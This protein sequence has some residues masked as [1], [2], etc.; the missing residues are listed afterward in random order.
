MTQAYIL[1]YRPQHINELDLT[2]IREGLSK[3]LKSNKVPHALLLTGPRGSGKTSAAR[4]ISKALNCQSKKKNSFEPCNRCSICQE[5][6]SGTSLDLMEVDAASTRGIDDIR[7]LREKVKLAPARLKNKVYIIDEVHMLTTEA[8]NALLKTLEEPPAN[9]YFILC[10]TNVEKLPETI[11]SRCTHYNFRKGKPDEIV[12]SLKRVVKGEKLKL[13]KGVLQEV[14]KNVDGSFRDAHKILDQLVGSK[15]KASLKE[16]KALLG[17]IEALSPKNLLAL[18]VENDLK[19]SLLEINRIVE[20]GGDLVVFVQDLLE[21]LRCGLLLR[22]GLVELEEPKEIRELDQFQILELLDLFSRAAGQIR[23]NP[24]PQLPLE[25]AVVEWSQGQKKA[26]SGPME[27]KVQ[28]RPP[29]KETVAEKTVVSPAGPTAVSSGKEIEEIEAKWQE[30]LTCIKPMNH[31]VEALL[32]SCRPINVNGNVITLEVFYRF[33][34]ERLE[35]DKCRR[36]FEDA[37]NQVFNK[38][39]RLKCILGEKGE[40]KPLSNSKNLPSEVKTKA[41]STSKLADLAES[42]IMKTAEEIFGN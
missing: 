2:D 12:D 18:L 26:E 5:I 6:T 13:E 17:K 25:L 38:S 15:K 16:V 21:R 37:F 35:E 39:V 33:H 22:S 41:S 8:F 20:A 27:S 29:V 36:I 11:I 31:S 1:K 4:I 19:Q 24:I 42:D 7:N 40:N 3:T 14:A 30:L 34:K 28:E 10:T 32:K 23:V 9:T